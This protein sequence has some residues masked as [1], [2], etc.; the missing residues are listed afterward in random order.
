MSGYLFDG[1]TLNK[2][3]SKNS[4]YGGATFKLAS[5]LNSDGII[6]YNEW[7]V[8]PKLFNDGDA[9]GKQTYAGSSLTFDRVGDTYT[10]SAAT[11]NNSN[12]QSNTLSGLQYFFN[13]SPTSGTTH[14]H[15]FT[16][17]FWPM[18][19]AAGRTDALWGKYGS[20]GSFQGYVESNNYKW[21]DLPANFPVSDDGKNHNWF[22]GMNFALNFNLTAD[23]EGP[24]EYYFFGDDDL[25]VFLDGKLV[26]DIGGVHSSIG[27][28][29]NLRDYL[30]NG[31]SGQHTLSFFYTERGASGSTC[32]M[33]FTLPSVS[34]A[35]TGRDIGQLQISKTLGGDAT[36]LDDVDYEFKVGLLTAEN[37]SGLNQTF[38]YS[39]SD[40]TY[41]TIKSGGTIALKAGDT[42][43]ISGIPAGTFYRVTE[44]EESRAGY[45]VTVNKNEGYIFKGT[46]ETGEVA[47]GDFV[48]TPYYELPSTGGNGTVWYS[49]GG[50]CLMAAAVLLYGRI[51]SREKE[52]RSSP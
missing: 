29:V 31:S 27:E 2:Y 26:C 1:S 39:R 5:G 9:T 47:K 17:N 18:D 8:A 32:Y 6:Q 7:I 50:L 36:G 40:G 22:F 25:W 21:S 49:A 35:T 13:P 24:L 46:I 20:P 44:A 34:N 23:Y 12:G 19:P 30:P 42:V 52:R 41:G 4:G 16:N 37:G 33:S 11:L 10:L 38:S 45:K 43:T 51:R 28:Y 3:S 48:N 14:T 15:I